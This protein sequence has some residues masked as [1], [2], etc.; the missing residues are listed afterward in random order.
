MEAVVVVVVAEE[1][2]QRFDKTNRDHLGGSG[3]HHGQAH[4]KH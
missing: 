1:S 2:L 3:E 4:H